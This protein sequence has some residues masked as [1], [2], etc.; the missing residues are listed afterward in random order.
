MCSSDL[1]DYSSQLEKKKSKAIRHI[2]L[3]RHGQ[4]NLDGATDKER[5]LTK[6]GEKQAEE[7]GKRLKSLGLKFTSLT[8]S[9]MTR[10][11]QTAEIIHKQI[12]NQLECNKLE[13]D[14]MLREGAPAPADPPVSNWHPDLHVRVA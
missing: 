12:E 1:E 10:A 5:V 13:M 11:I 3:I 2:I 7:T 6:L 8:A 14:P 9:T 4:Y